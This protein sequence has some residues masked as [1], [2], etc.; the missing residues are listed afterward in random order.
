MSERIKLSVLS[1]LLLLAL[2]FSAFT[3]A[4]TFQAVRNLQLQNH[5]V[6]VGNVSTIRAWM[7]VPAISRIY[8]IPEDYVYRSLEISNP[9]SYHHVTL[10]EIANRKQQPVDQVIHNLQHAILI[11]RKQHPGITIPSRANHSSKKHLS[12]VLGRAEP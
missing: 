8:H 12:P 2:L 10:Y 11:Y 6:K 3:T 1:A 7:T 4:N 5:D 9:A